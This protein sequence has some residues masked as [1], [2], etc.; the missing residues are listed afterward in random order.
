MTTAHSTDA[1]RSAAAAPVLEA[2]MAALR[3][4]DLEAVARCYHPDVP[5]LDEAGIHHG[6]GT[7]QARHRHISLRAT[8]WE[9][10]QQQGSKA[11]LRWI[12]RGLGG[13]VQA[14]GA[15][16]IEIIDGQVVFAA[17]A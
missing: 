12:R 9:D 1:D 2:L 7:A 4:N 5:W 17:E 15:I 8:E 6:R 16:V 10:P 11:V 13:A 3:A 14:R